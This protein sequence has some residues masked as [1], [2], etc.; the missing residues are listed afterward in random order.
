MIQKYDY[1]STPRYIRKRL[2]NFRP[3]T[4]TAKRQLKKKNNMVIR[5]K[6][7][8]VIH[9][10]VWDE[11]EDESIGVVEC[12]NCGFGVVLRKGSATE[13]ASDIV[14]FS[15]GHPCGQTN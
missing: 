1:K 10:E 2:R 6:D 7:G 8:R 3:S 12:L 9:F 13:I 4:G 11:P 14:K 15:L 5:T